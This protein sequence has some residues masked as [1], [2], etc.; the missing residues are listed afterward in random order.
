M[1]L[2]H[3]SCVA[4]NG[5]AILLFGPSGSGKSDL[6]L[7]LIDAGATL[8]SD[9][10]VEVVARQGKAVATAPER[11]AGLI[12]ARGVGLLSCAHTRS[13]PI[14][15]A[16]D[17]DPEREIVRLP[18]NARTELAG[19]SVPLIVLRAFEASAVAKVRLLLDNLA[20]EGVANG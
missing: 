3:A 17:L 13:C 5:K 7:R 20:G 19:I 10:Y 18:E 1:N 4:I 15:L 9:D 11:I 16:V 6:A 14:G 2:V 8:V 12:E